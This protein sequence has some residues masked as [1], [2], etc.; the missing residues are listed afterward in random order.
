M[1]SLVSII[2]VVFN[3]AEEIAACLDSLR[4]Q[5]YEP[6]EVIVYDNSSTDGSGALI[7][8]CFPEVQLI[9]GPLNIGFAAASNYA[10]SLAQG[11]FLA[12]LNPDTTVESNW[13]LPLVDALESDHRVGAVSPTL[14][15]AQTPDVVNAC[16]N[17]MHLSG[18]TYCRHFG[19]AY[20]D[21]IPQ[22]VGAVSGAALVIRR[23]LFERMNGFEPTFFMYYEDT[24]L[25]LKL[26]RAGYQCLAVPESRVRHA[27]K[28]AMGL[29]KLFF[30]E[31][32]RFLSLFSL[33]SWRVLALMAPSL[34]LIEAATW[35]Y[36]L[37]EGRDTLTTK[38]RAWCDVLNRLP[39]VRKRRGIY[40]DRC[41]SHASIIRALSP[42]L[43]VHCT[44]SHSAVLLRTLEGAAWI[45]AAPLLGLLRFL[46]PHD[47][48]DQHT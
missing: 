15:F 35:C 14:V 25:S 5:T 38:A 42:R 30:L 21:G 3:N 17:E 10:A 1:T 46:G 7:Q 34:L 2:V 32:N 28:E 23:G 48:A 45:T 12:F 13:L 26:R 41:T 6:S 22:E 33:M 9:R 44:P 27:Y 24:D 31:R 4:G 16:G 8:N 37:I 47:Q 39:W 11:D 19:R 43:K 20:T 40:A 29:D 18:M 36:C